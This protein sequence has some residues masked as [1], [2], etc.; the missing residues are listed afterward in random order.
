MKQPHKH[1]ELIKAWADG[2]LI[3]VCNGVV[4]E[5]GW[6]DINSPTWYL[7]MKY[8]I[9]P[10]QTDLEIY[11]VEVGDIWLSKSETLHAVMEVTHDVLILTIEHHNVIKETLK[12]LVFRRGVVNKL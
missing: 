7:D 10:V 4:E 1:A 8:R 11:S 9:K 12:T 3:Q 2:A 6:V 5:L